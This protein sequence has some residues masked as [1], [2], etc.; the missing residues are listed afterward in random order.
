M[1]VL[2]YW[3]YLTEADKASLY[4]AFVFMAVIG[5]YTAFIYYFACFGSRQIALV[6]KADLMEETSEQ[7][8]FIHESLAF[9]REYAGY[10]EPEM[11]LVKKSLKLSQARRE[12]KIE[13]ASRVNRKRL[14]K[15]APLIV[16]VRKES[17]SAML[18]SPILILRRLSMLF[19]ALFFRANGTIHLQV[20]ISLNFISLYHAYKIRPYERRALNIMNMVNESVSVLTACL[21][22]TQQD[23]RYD[24][25]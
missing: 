22:L 9:Q 6:S 4:L 17:H 2:G 11:Q 16:G 23:M 3:D 12:L 24:P 13:K 10:S 1:K 19:M 25:L 18:G 14:S 21:L 7:C 8:S 15:Y 20:F 5:A